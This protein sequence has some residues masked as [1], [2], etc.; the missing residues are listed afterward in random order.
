ML[1]IKPSVLM[2]PAVTSLDSAAYDKDQIK[3][4]ADCDRA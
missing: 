2:P 3:R 4:Q 1:G